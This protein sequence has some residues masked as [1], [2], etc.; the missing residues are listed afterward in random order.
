MALALVRLPPRVA[1]GSREGSPRA[2]TNP[3]SPALPGPSSRAR[4]PLRAP[5]RRAA[6]PTSPCWAR[7]RSAAA[8]P[9]RARGARR[10]RR[11]CVQRR[12]HLAP[13]PLLLTHPPPPCR[14]SLRTPSP[15]RRSRRCA[16]TGCPRPC[17]P[18]RAP[19]PRAPAPTLTA[20]R[21]LPRA[22]QRLHHHAGR[23][24]AARRRRRRGAARGARAWPPH[25]ARRSLA[26][27]RLPLLQPTPCPRP[28]A[29]RLLERAR[30]RAFS[31]PLPPR[32]V[33]GAP[34]NPH[35]PAP[36]RAGQQGRRR[37]PRRAPRGRGGRARAA[38]ACLL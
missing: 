19:R 3:P 17:V 2:R 36:A 34:L 37:G 33:R 32:R 24:V 28:N 8:S 23:A 13:A 12:A 16:A 25:R 26:P 10:P 14:A 38:A 7:R 9:R 31:P 22:A 1:L 20:P 29:G 5:R 11:T 18:R 4:R 27:R 30:A 35:A 21:S 15:S 6:A